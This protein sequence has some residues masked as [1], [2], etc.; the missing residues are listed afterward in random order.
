MASY[1]LINNT[2]LPTPLMSSKKHSHEKGLNKQVF[3]NRM[4]HFKTKLF[5][6]QSSVLIPSIFLRAFIWLTLC[7]KSLFEEIAC[8]CMTALS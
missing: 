7:K 6:L 4:C 8:G 2:R 5:G 3:G 1:V